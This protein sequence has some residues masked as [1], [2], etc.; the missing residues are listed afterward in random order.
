MN[1]ISKYLLSVITIT[2]LIIISAGCAGS[3][4]PVTAVEDDPAVVEAEVA[5]TEEEASDAEVSV[6]DV[7]VEMWHW[8]ANKE[9]L[10]QEAIAEYQALH[11]NVTIVTNVIPGDTWDQTLAAALIGGEAPALFHGQPKGPVLEQWNNEQIVDLTS[12]I[13]EEW[14]EALYPSTWDVLT[15]DG[16]VMSMSF[17]T[18]NIQM[19]YN[20]SRFKELGIETPIQTMSDLQDA[21]TTLRE[22]GYGAGLYWASLL[23]LTPQFFIDYATQ[24]YPEEFLAADIGEGRWD[25]DEFNQVMVDVNAFSDIWEEGVVSLSLD[26]S[27]NAFSTGDVS[28]YFIGN[29]AINSIM[30]NEPGFDIAVQPVPALNDQ[31]GFSALA[32]NAGTWM[33]SNQKPIEVQEAAIDFLR[34]FA[35][36][37]QGLIVEAIGLCPAGPAGESALENAHEL[38]RQLCDDADILISRDMFTKV[39]Q[40]EMASA[41]QG[42]LTGNLAPEDVLIAA[43]E[44]KDNQ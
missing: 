32:S 20:E 16:K 6:E 19:F 23:Q 14:K 8:A 42:L 2:I 5:D 21:S 33:V 12:Y 41:V 38:A 7:V 43:Q 18:N 40:N 22:N 9:P 3:T 31:T 4:E 24:L 35:L 36:N 34:W 44:A 1:K 29:W 26:E 28:F 11:P 17:A 37:Q 10:Y 15:I 30:A 25:T 39:V 13:D 27:V